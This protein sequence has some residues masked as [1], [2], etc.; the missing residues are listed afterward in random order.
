MK[1]NRLEFRFISRYIKSEYC[2]VA[3][4]EF[5][6]NLK[7]CHVPNL[8]RFMFVDVI[9][10][11]MLGGFEED[12]LYIPLNQVP[13]KEVEIEVFITAPNGTKASK[14]HKR[15]S[16]KNNKKEKEVSVVAL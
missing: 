14:H 9:E 1:R 4:W 12:M 10:P 13:D 7:C 6:S 2:V 15:T 3:G 8:N 11:R 16:K 5:F